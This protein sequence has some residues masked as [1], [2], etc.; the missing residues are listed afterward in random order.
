[1]RNVQF[2]ADGS[3]A[4]LVSGALRDTAAFEA[5][6]RAASVVVKAA[7]LS[8][9]T[10]VI[11]TWDSDYPKANRICTELGFENCNLI[12]TG[13]RSIPCDFSGN[14]IRQS[15]LLTKG[16]TAISPNSFV[17]KMRTDKTEWVTEFAKQVFHLP[18][19]T[20]P[21]SS[22]FSKRIII[23]DA[24]VLEPYFYNDMVYAG[25]ASDLLRLV[26]R[27][28]QPLVE[29][30]IINPE[31]I[32]HIA[33]VLE[34]NED[35]ARFF[36]QNRGLPH[37]YEP[38]QLKLRNEGI[39]SDNLHLKMAIQSL[40]HLL[41]AYAFPSD[42][43]KDNSDS[44]DLISYVGNTKKRLVEVLSCPPPDSLHHHLR[45]N[46]SARSL[47]LT[48]THALRILLENLKACALS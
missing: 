42:Y 45:F 29:Q 18:E 16:L 39:L 43:D 11:S 12:V 40:E 4:I 48:S 41:Q 47:V 19:L 34:E 2:G 13:S 33:P 32:F 28:M 6:L 37:G 17:I 10:I 15:I 1:M 14:W 7:G 5:S 9:A 25:I 36:R 24:I 8:K 35:I 31:Q 26:P 21:Q 44:D 3:F 38:E 27:L 23:P 30:W 46:D 22:S 20:D